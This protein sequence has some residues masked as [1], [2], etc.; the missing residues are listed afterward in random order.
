MWSSGVKITTFSVL[1]EKTKF[2]KQ[3]K[4]K[5]VSTHVG[6]CRLSMFSLV[7][8]VTALLLLEVYFKKMMTSYSVPLKISISCHKVSSEGHSLPIKLKHRSQIRLQ[9]IIL[10][11]IH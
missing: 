2:S 8:V 4:I 6:Y 9:K 1:C 10:N 5:V 7:K 11:L 3:N